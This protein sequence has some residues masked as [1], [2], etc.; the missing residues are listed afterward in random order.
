MANILIQPIEITSRS[1]NPVRITGFD[2]LASTD[3]IIGQ[4]T[5]PASGDTIDAAWD[6]N[7]TMRGGSQNTNLDMHTAEMKDLLN[8]IHQIGN[9]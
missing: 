4:I 7:G 5:L 2:P 6:L 3:Q 8:L 1:G 9:K